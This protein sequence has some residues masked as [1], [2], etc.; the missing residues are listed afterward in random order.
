MTIHHLNCCTFCPRGALLLGAP[1]GHRVEMCC[2][3]LLVETERSGLVLIETGLGLDDVREGAA[4]LG[5]GF[6]FMTRPAFD[7]HETAHA[8][9]K[10]LG[11]S[12]SDVR[13]IVVT[14]LDVDHAGGISDFPQ[15]DVHVFFAEHR[16]AM[17]RATVQSR[18]RYIP[19]QWAHRVR[20]QLHDELA[21]ERWFGFECVRQLGDLPPDILLVPLLGHSAGHCGVAARGADGWLLHAGDAYFHR[22]E[23]TAP[24]YRGPWGFEAFQRLVGH[25]AKQ[26][27][28]NQHRLRELKGQH[29]GEVR[30]FSAHDPVEFAALRD[31]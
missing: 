7:P 5:R 24:H 19:A 29:S 20:W 21:G 26:R 1:W 12:P 27:I 4:R 15:A 2:H 11:L 18:T 10:A 3:C 25:D 6:T 13:H 14:H 22:D 16:A 30:V 23:M 9:I 31:R 17:S 28:A 8:R